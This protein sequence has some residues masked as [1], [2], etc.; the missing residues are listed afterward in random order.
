MSNTYNNVLYV[1]VTNDLVRR[2]A[3]HK[4]KVNKGFTYKYNV[5]KLVYFEQYNLMTY[6][7]AREKQLKNWKR[8]WKNA[9]IVKENPEWKDLSESIGVD[10]EYIDAVKS[11]YQEIAGQARND[12]NASDIMP[13]DLPTP[14]K[15]IIALE[16]EAIKKLKEKNKKIMT[17][18]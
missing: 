14:E 7:I 17:D 8:E 6:A 1:G 11:H 9:L 16:K 15:G 10:K 3:E 2:V 13:E 18:E 12:E 5:D 4:A